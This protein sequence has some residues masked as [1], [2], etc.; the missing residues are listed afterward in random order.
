MITFGHR[1]RLEYKSSALKA[2]K[3]RVIESSLCSPQSRQHF[4]TSE[5][6]AAIDAGSVTSIS[7]SW[8]PY[9][10]VSQTPYSL[11][12]NFLLIYGEKQVICVKLIKI[13]CIIGWTDFILCH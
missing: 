11:L 8:R 4:R 2:S 5:N 1:A 12:T 10:A 3:F 13:L 6:L 7:E 9:H